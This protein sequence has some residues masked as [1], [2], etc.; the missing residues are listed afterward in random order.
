MRPQSEINSLE[1]A[2]KSTAASW[3]SYCARSLVSILLTY[4]N[5][6]KPCVATWRKK[7]GSQCSKMSLFSSLPRWR[8]RSCGGAADSRFVGGVDHASDDGQPFATSVVGSNR[9]AS[10]APDKIPPGPKLDALTAEKVL[11]WKNVHKHEGALVGKKQDKAGHWRRAKVPSYS[12]N[13]S[14]RIW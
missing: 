4:L 6:A 10:K 12:T 2:R 11:G 9:M 8:L 1:S 13:P 5:H 3:C 7:G 14:T